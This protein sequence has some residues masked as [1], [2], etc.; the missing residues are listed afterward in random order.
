M[1]D[2]ARSYSASSRSSFAA[3][4]GSGR[5]AAALPAVFGSW[6]EGLAFGSSPPAVASPTAPTARRDAQRDDTRDHPELSHHHGPQMKV[7]QSRRP[8]LTTTRRVPRPPRFWSPR[9][10]CSSP[11]PAGT[12]AR[13]V[14]SSTATSVP[15]AGAR[16][17]SVQAYAQ[18][19]PRPV[20]AALHRADRATQPRSGL[21]LGEPLQI[22]KHHRRSKACRQAR[23]LGVDDGAKF[24]PLAHGR[25]M[26]TGRS[27]RDHQ[28]H[29][30]M[31]R[32]L[33][34]VARR[35]GRLAR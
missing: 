29:A 33:T 23:D 35:A 27:A 17:R 26:S 19:L 12:A 15:T 34:A 20:Q 25:M 2:W 6:A 30:A 7:R 18:T 4:G 21:F 24:V 3:S 13:D 31:R 11:C 32:C 16:P 1:R 28:G 10:P 5:P 8:T 14:R 22:A 9:P